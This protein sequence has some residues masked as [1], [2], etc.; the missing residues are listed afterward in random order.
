MRF[1][2]PA[3]VCVAACA[4]AVSAAPAVAPALFVSPLGSDSGSCSSTQPCRSLNAAYRLARPGQVVE[5]R[6]GRYP[7]QTLEAVSGKGAPAVVF[8][9]ARGVRPVFDSLIDHASHVAFAGLTM[10]LFWTVEN[11]ADDVTIRNVNTGV[12][13]IRSATNVS[14]IGGSVGPWESNKLAGIEDTQIG[15]W[16]RAHYPQPRKILISGAKLREPAQHLQIAQSARRVFD[17]R[18]EVINRFL[19]L[20]VALVSELHDVAAE[21]GTG[22]ADLTE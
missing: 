17:V 22:I 2:W 5:I 15:D 18:F 16:D 1:L 3:V 13:T 4:S 6:A 19:E 8:R 11:A 10:R 20:G 9:A 12:F 7:A 21:F 14:V